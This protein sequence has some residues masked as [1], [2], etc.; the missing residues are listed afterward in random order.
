M[1]FLGI[2][3]ATEV[4]S[5]VLYHNEQLIAIEY[6]DNPKAHSQYLT[7]FIEKVLRTANI[8]PKDINAV[9]LSEGP[10]SYTGLRIGMSAAKGIAYA[11]DIPLMLIPS[12][13]VAAYSGLSYISQ[14]N[15]TV[16]GIIDAPNKE[17][18]IQCFTVTLRELVS[19]MPPRHCIADENIL[20]TLDINTER[21]VYLSGKGASKIKQCY[22]DNENI[23]VL[24]KAKQD[25]QNLGKWL[26]Q[27]Y[28]NKVFADTELCEPLYI[29][30][31]LPI[32]KPKK[33][34]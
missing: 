20:F 3:T 7:L 16:A 22:P 23:I 12:T 34:K 9:V 1:Y 27:T 13:M 29:K 6:T 32:L 31:F 25:M 8:T 17:L 21:P 11:L 2:E 28:Q 10:G 30:D 26:T 33:I 5:V 14:D 15:A 4:C 18:F 19:I 24:D